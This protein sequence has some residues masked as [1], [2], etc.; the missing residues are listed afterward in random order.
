MIATRES[1]QDIFDDPVGVIE[2]GSVIRDAAGDLL[3]FMDVKWWT[4]PRLVY[5]FEGRK[6]RRFVE[7]G[8]TKAARYLR[9]RR[10]S[11]PLFYCTGALFSIICPSHTG[12]G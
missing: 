11:L 4:A 7:S 5:L 3:E 10:V 2:R 1:R 12:E 8:S 9:K 6:D